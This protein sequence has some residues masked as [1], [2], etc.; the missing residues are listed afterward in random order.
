MYCFSDR[1]TP[2]FAADGEEKEAFA[3]GAAAPGGESAS[4]EKEQS[5]KAQRRVQPGHDAAQA[6]EREQKRRRADARTQERGMLFFLHERMQ[7]I[8]GRKE[9]GKD[10]AQAD[11]REQFA[12]G[13][14]AHR[15]QEGHFRR[16]GARTLARDAAEHRGRAK[17]DENCRC[18]TARTAAPGL[19]AHVAGDGR[20]EKGVHRRV[21]QDHAAA[22]KGARRRGIGKTRVIGAGREAEHEREDERHQHEIDGI[23]AVYPPAR[24]K[25]QHYQRRESE[26]GKAIAKAEPLAH[27]GIH[28]REHT[29]AQHQR[30]AEHEHPH[31]GREPAEGKAQ[32][33][34]IAAVFFAQP[35]KR[36]KEDAKERGAQSR[37]RHEPLRREKAHQFRAGYEPRADDRAHERGT[38]F[39][40]RADTFQ[41]NCHTDIYARQRE[42]MPRPAALA[43]LFCSKRSAESA[44]LPSLKNFV[45]IVKNAPKLFDNKGGFCYNLLALCECGCSSMVEFQPSKLAAWVRFPSPAPKNAKSEESSKQRMRL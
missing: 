15:V 5:R 43:Y 25:V 35:Q 21:Q 42:A 6:E 37:P 16:I 18:H 45:Q 27:G 7:R 34:R 32:H 22:V 14:A 41:K 33:A 2:F 38:H 39:G 12:D 31:G 9:R 23:H 10:A 1:R 29:A 13:A 8:I 44:F 11:E 36:V 24:Q 30:T 4:G 40:V 26:K 19:C 17:A 3:P 28:P 20:G